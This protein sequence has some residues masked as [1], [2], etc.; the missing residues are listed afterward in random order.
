MKKYRIL[1]LGVSAAVLPLLIAVSVVT[2][3]PPSPR[4]STTQPTDEIPCQCIDH[5]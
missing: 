3:E 4:S 1:F 2:G 5:L